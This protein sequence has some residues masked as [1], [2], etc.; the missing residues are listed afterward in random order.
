[1]KR[2]GFPYF[3]VSQFGLLAVTEFPEENTNLVFVS[4]KASGMNRKRGIQGFKGLWELF[5]VGE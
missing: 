2:C 5:L 1:M 3:E 4:D